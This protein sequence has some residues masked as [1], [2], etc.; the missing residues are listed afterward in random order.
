MPTW[1]RLALPSATDVL[2]IALLTTLLFTPLSVRLL[3]DAGIG[4]HVRTGQQILTVHAVPRVDP[5]STQIQKPWIAWEWLYDVIVG[6]LES[7]AGLNGVVWFTAV[8]IATVFAWA[9]RLLIVRGVHVLI[10]VLLVLVAMSA[11]MIHFLARP[12]VL[13]WL[14]TLAWFW[15]LQS[16]ER[17]SLSGNSKL[18]GKL[19]WAL[20]LLMLV[21]VNVH[22]G[23]VVGFVL[24]GIFWLGALWDWMRARETRIEDVLARIAAGKRVKTLAGAGLLS[25]TASLANPYEWK[26]HMHVYSYLSDRFLMNHIEEFR[27]PDFHGVAQEC[28][29]A[30]LL[31]ALATVAVRDRQLR[32]SELLTMLFAVYA[33]LYA[34]RNIPI[35]S[36]LVVIIVGPLLSLPGLGKKFFQ[37]MAAV[38]SGLRGHL[39]PIAATVATLMIA[40][41]GGRAGSALLMNAHFDPQRM[42]VAA[43]DFLR[44]QE[45]PAL[46]AGD[47]RAARLPQC[48][49]HSA[50]LSPDYWGGYLIYRLYPDNK[51]VIDDRHDFYD[52]WF[53]TDYL[54]MVHVEPGWGEFLRWRGA[55]LVLPRKAALTQILTETPAWEPVYKDDVAVVFVRTNWP[56]ED[57]DKTGT[58]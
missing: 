31:I 56:P 2:F 39:W 57:R 58:P 14:F 10:A 13:S 50:V 8:V 48:R 44:D 32:I 27:S 19:L 18:L 40:I 47:V 5:F 46:A 26:L 21:W 9:L 12:H 42:P 55:C 53:L 4:W 30:L 23:F 38:E 28:F 3:G 16:T 51:V 11:S 41:H 24:L 20:P 43:V 29:L 34:S 52:E 6:L 33:G 54:T 1:A 15:I 49:P 45:A 22:G 7:S 25:L 17:E 35:S 36:L 37:R